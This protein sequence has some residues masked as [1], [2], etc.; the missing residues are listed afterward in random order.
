[1]SAAVTALIHGHYVYGRAHLGRNGDPTFT[2]VQ[3]EHPDGTIT[4]LGMIE[5]ERV[6]RRAVDDAVRAWCRRQTPV[7][8]DEE[9]RA[10]MRYVRARLRPKRKPEATA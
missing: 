6:R 5:G 2:G 9:D 10:A 7:I 3:V 8:W 1:M 4:H